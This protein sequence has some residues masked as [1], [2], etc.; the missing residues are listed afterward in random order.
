[1]RRI[2]TFGLEVKPFL[3]HLQHQP[4]ADI[5]QAAQLQGSNGPAQR[6]Q[7]VVLPRLLRKL[8]PDLT[9]GEHH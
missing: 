2:D 7:A 5:E 8:R 4:A 1:L 6:L 3:R 9:A